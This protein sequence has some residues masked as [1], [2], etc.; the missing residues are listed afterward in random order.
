M[1]D[2]KTWHSRHQLIEELFDRWSEEEEDTIS[3]SDEAP[4]HSE[5]EPIR[6]NDEEKNTGE[7]PHPADTVVIE[8]IEPGY[9]VEESN[10]ATQPMNPL[11]NGN[12]SSKDD[13]EEEEEEN[14]LID[15]R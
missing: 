10:N 4:S 8:S 14:D 12:H 15:L 11:G 6:S 13:D 2:N 9:K 7:R 5:D 3:V 1:T